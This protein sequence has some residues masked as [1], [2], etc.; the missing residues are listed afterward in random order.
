M[1]HFVLKIAHCVTVL[2]GKLLQ[3]QDKLE[4]CLIAIGRPIPSSIFWLTIGLLWNIFCHFLHSIY[5]GRWLVVIGSVLWRGKDEQ[6]EGNKGSVTCEDV[7]S[8]YHRLHQI[9]LSG[10]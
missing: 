9:K 4:L 10:K 2:Q 6:L 5:V 1:V 8:I 7:A 3:A